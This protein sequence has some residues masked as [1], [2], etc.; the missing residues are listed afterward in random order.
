MMPY[1]HQKRADGRLG[2]GDRVRAG[3]AL[4]GMFLI[5]LVAFIPCLV[6]FGLASLTGRKN[7][8]TAV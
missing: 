8:K 1:A 7:S 5:W 3:L 2:R 4:A 6:W